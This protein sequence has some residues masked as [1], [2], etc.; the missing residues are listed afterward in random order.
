[1]RPI[2]VALNSIS[3]SNPIVLDRGR[4]PTNVAIGV[5]ITVGTATYS[6]QYTYD[7]PFAV[8]FNPSTAKWFTHSTLSAL[9]ADGDGNIAFPAR[10]VRLNV[11]AVGGGGIVTMTLIQS[12]N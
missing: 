11:A 10:A 1:M 7:D 2:T 12:G 9:S 4:V 6:V 8:G 5:K 3:V